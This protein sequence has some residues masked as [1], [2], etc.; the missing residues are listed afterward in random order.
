MEKIK[1][2]T[3]LFFC[4]IFNLFIKNFLKWLINGTYKYSKYDMKPT[5][6]KPMTYNNYT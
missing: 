6:I 3:D 1:K 2:V 5:N 4:K